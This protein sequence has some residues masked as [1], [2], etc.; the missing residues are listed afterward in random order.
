MVKT[1]GYRVELGE[2]EAALHADPRVA[3]AVAVA[4]PDELLGSR[5]VAFCTLADGGPSAAAEDADAEADPVAAIR[6]GCAER[7]PDYMIPARIVVGSEPLPRI[8][9]DKHDRQRLTEQAVRLQEA[10]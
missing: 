5:I 6:R 10:P 2:I 7:L 3:E 1:R 8:S 4:V 9:T